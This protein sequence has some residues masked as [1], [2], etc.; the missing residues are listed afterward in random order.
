[1]KHITTVQELNGLTFV[2][3]Y[4][5]H[6]LMGKVYVPSQASKTR[7]GKLIAELHGKEQVN[8]LRDW[9]DPTIYR[10]EVKR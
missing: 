10:Y 2:I 5:N 3:F 7:L 9:A 8:A 6:D 1:M 4:R